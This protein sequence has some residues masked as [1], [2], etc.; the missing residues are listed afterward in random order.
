MCAEHRYEGVK[1]QSW[2]QRMKSVG[3]FSPC[4]FPKQKKFRANSILS[5]ES[6]GRLEPWFPKEWPTW[7]HT[8]LLAFLVL[9]GLPCSL[10]QYLMAIP[11]DHCPNSHTL[12]PSPCL[13]LCL[14]EDN[15][16]SWWQLHMGWGVRRRKQ[17]GWLQSFLL[18]WLNK[19]E[20]LSL[21]NSGIQ[22]FFVCGRGRK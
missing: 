20:Y 13:R 5:S 19:W 3:K 21:T 15:R 18:G 14:Q 2:Q 11:W 10:L 12:H 1:G 9:T 22:G 6:P 4:S 16:L 8:L 17:E 7:G